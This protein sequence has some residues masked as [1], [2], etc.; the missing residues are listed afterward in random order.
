[1]SPPPSLPSWC[2]T[3]WSLALND[4]GYLLVDLLASALTH[5]QHTLYIAARVILLKHNI[6][7]AVY[8]ICSKFFLSQNNSQS[9]YNHLPRQRIKGR[10]ITL[11]RKYSQ[12]YSFSS[13][14]V[15]MWELDHKEGWALKNWCWNC[16]AGEDSWESLGQQGDQTSQS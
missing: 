9:T 5:R 12:S 7:H 16:G 4:C 13:S 2:K 1:M 3:L 14:H 8:L 15:Q 10:D 11:P 6:N